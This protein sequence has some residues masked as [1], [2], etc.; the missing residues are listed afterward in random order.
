MATAVLVQSPG[1]AT[2]GLVFVAIGIAGS[3]GP[4][5][6]LATA[7]LGGSAAEIALI[8]SIG[9]VGAPAG[10][11]LAGRVRDATGGFGIALL[12]FAALAVLAAVLTSLRW[13]GTPASGGPSS[14]ARTRT[15][16]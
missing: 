4:F 15:P 3:F 10:S 1:L 6:G 14:P 5:W 16:T 13:A 8:S 12:A 7:T 11:Y 9:Q 2:V